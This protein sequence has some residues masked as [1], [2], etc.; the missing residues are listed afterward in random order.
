ME[1]QAQTSK[2]EKQMPHLQDEHYS[3]PRLKMFSLLKKKDQQEIAACIEETN[4]LTDLCVH[5]LEKACQR[6][7]TDPQDTNLLELHD[8]IEVCKS[9]LKLQE[10]WRTT[11]ETHLRSANRVNPEIKDALNRS[12]SH[13]DNLLIKI[14]FAEEHCAKK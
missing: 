5:L 12:A 4:Q 8:A 9:E 13:R 6:F 11:I 1:I 10:F 14:V 3:T 7:R 2:F